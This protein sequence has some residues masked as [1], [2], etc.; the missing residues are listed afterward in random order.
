MSEGEIE[1]RLWEERPRVYSLERETNDLWG[2]NNFWR[3]KGRLNCGT[4]QSIVI[5]VGLT[6]I[7]LLCSESRILT[8]PSPV[9]RLSQLVYR[10]FSDLVSKTSGPLPVIRYTYWYFGSSSYPW[11]LAFLWRKLI[12]NT[13]NNIPMSPTGLPVDC[14]VPQFNRP[15]ILQT[16]YFFSQIVASLSKW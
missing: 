15:F 5:P 10:C 14:Q 3:V 11:K 9:I 4:W 1:G 2:K 12:S 8:G 16:L 6:G 7:L 13:W